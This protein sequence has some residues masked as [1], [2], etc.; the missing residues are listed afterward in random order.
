MFNRSFERFNEIA[1]AYREHVL[2]P[3]RRNYY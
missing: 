1:A 3:V 2:N